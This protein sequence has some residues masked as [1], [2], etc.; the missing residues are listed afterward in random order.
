MHVDFLK[1]NHCVCGGGQS[2]DHFRRFFADIWGYLMRCI[3]LIVKTLGIIRLLSIMKFSADAVCERVLTV[4]KKRRCTFRSD[5]PMNLWS[6]PPELFMDDHN[7]MAGLL[8]SPSGY[9][10]GG[11]ALIFFNASCFFVI[12]SFPN[13]KRQPNMF[14]SSTL[15]TLKICAHPVASPRLLCALLKD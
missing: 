2:C 11:D 7:E 4:S 9:R 15:R 10:G 6:G 3:L 8:T 13:V 12:I 1:G 14:Q 5:T